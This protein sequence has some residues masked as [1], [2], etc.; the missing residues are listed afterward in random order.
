M[1]GL[2]GSDQQYFETRFPD[3]PR[4]A[5]LWQHLTAYLAQ[6]VPP[7]AAVLELAAGYCHFINHVPA[8]RRVA[9]DAG[10]QVTSAASPGVEAHQADAIA[11]LETVPTG[12]FDVIFA[13]N[14]LEHLDRADVE[15]I[16]PLILKAL[17][18]GGRFAIVQPN[19]R[20]APGRYFDDYT[21][22]TMFTDVSICDWFT[23]AGFRIVKVVPR[24]LPLTVKSSLG[25]FTFLVPLYLRLPWRPLAGQMFVLAERPSA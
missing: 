12:T 1:S 19:F 7:N 20:L 5:K 10:P 18:P 15:R 25:G 6:F 17:K 4:R 21:H 2:T 3:D 14:F 22:R 24:F 11:F 13:S 9:V 16:L 23:A 8:A